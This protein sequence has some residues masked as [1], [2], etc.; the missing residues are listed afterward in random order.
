M[1]R[2]PPFLPNLPRP[3]G[4]RA[5]SVRLQFAAGTDICPY[6]FIWQSQACS[7]G[8]DDARQEDNRDS[9]HLITSFLLLDGRQSERTFEMM[10]QEGALPRLLELIQSRRDDDGPLHRKLLELLYEMSRIQRLRLE[11]L[12]KCRRS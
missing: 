4:L 2:P 5:T 3:P 11:D 9:L 7:S 12:R 8:A 10:N 1:L 6:D